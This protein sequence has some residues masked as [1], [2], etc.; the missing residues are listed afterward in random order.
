MTD[1]ERVSEGIDSLPKSL[2]EAIKYMKE[3]GFIKEVLGDHIF[4]KYVEAKNHEW[5]SYRTRVS[6]WEINEYLEKY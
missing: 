3:D 2:E 5:D 1:E 4:S 6:Q